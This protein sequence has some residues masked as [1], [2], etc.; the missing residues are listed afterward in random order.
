[1]ATLKEIA[2]KSNTSITTVSRVLNYD[3]TLSVSEEMRKKIIDTASGMNYRTPRN[4]TKIK[5]SKKIRV[6]IVHW[7][8]IHEE[9]DDPYYIQIRRGIEK[10]ASKSN[11]ETTLIYKKSDTF[12]FKDSGH[13]DGLICIG[14][15][16]RAQINQF[17]RV[18]TSIVFVDSSP[19]IN[20]YDSVVIDFTK[21]VE[22]LLQELLM[23]GYNAIGYLGGTE[24]VS[25]SIKLG[26][27][28]ELV[29]RNFLFER[30]K[31][32]TRFI[33]IGAFSTESG[34]LMMKEALSK[35][36]Y[37]RAYFCANDSIALGA[38]RAIHE[39]RL[40]IPEDIAIVGFN[41]NPN[42]EFTYPP[43]S[44]VKVYTE[45]MGEQALFS[46]NEKIEGRSIPIKKIIPTKLVKRSTF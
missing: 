10:L 27:R 5:T 8:N 34:Y 45:F 9:I 6:G 17:R 26:E 37:A 28:Q 2:L 35:S 16:S 30:N 25:K 46:L 39:K 19:D 41:D 1:M 21:A 42:S 33:H 38:M 43:L 23:E 40:K 31:L 22:E 44:T 12:N 29:F 32:D 3:K 18:T 7:Y 36:E 20:V 4:R 11:I 13:F 15:F 14:K 24:Y